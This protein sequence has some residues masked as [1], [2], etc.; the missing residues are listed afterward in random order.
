MNPLLVFGVFCSSIW[1]LYAQES[2]D[3]TATAMPKKIPISRPE[4]KRALELLKSRQPRLPLPPAAEGESSVNN[5]RAR[6]LYLP[7]SWRGGQAGNQSRLSSDVASRG[8]RVETGRR[9]DPAMTLDSTFKVRL[10]WIVSRVNNC[11]Y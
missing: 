10:F 11:Q 5:G 3:L 8:E 4:M 1:S 7:E 9:G 2:N 6:A